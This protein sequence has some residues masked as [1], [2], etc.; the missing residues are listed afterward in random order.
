[1]GFNSWVVEGFQGEKPTK[2]SVL[3]HEEVLSTLLPRLLAH[4][5]TAR[6][7][8]RHMCDDLQSVYTS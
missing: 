8:V 5:S 3:G 2:F 4:T 7:F 1:M 6:D